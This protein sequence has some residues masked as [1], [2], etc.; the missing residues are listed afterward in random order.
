MPPNAVLQSSNISC[1]LL[2]EPSV[3]CVLITMSFIPSATSFN[4]P[5]AIVIMIFLSAIVALPACKPLSLN[6][7]KTEQTSSI[8]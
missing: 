4:S 8:V 3:F 2:I 7:I 6:T 1:K 5:P